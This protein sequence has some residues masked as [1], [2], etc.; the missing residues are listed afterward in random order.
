MTSY[1]RFFQKNAKEIDD[2]FQSWLRQHSASGTELRV[3]SL[4]HLDSSAWTDIKDDLKN[5]LGGQLNGTAKD[6]KDKG[7]AQIIL[8]HMPSEYRPLGKI[9][10]SSVTFVAAKTHKN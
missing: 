5:I 2:Q 1:E 4:K 9:N 7:K 6:Y 10:I 3:I 8:K